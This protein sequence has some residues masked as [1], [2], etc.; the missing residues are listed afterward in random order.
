M[1]FSVKLITGILRD[2]DPSPYYGTIISESGPGARGR[3]RGDHWPGIS[4]MPVSRDSDG[5][6]GLGVTVR[7]EHQ[8]EVQRP[9]PLPAALG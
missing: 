3:S 6:P 7:G 2:Y 1:K 9:R 8:V 5:G 4:T